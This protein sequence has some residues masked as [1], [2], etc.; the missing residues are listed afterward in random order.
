MHFLFALLRN[1]PMVN[2]VMALS[3]HD[4]DTYYG[5]G[6]NE[7]P[8]FIAEDIRLGYCVITADGPKLTESGLQAVLEIDRAFM[9]GELVL[10]EQGEAALA[11]GH[12]PL[13]A[14]LVDE[15]GC[16]SPLLAEALL[17]LQKTN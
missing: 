9:G 8:E 14:A 2:F 3:Q 1:C 12:N 16:V 11:F 6:N 5:P 7:D 17:I 10:T 4:L 15:D 13:L